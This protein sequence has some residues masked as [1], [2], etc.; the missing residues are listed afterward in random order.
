MIVS[1]GGGVSRSVCCAAPAV[2]TACLRINDLFRAPASTVQDLDE[3]AAEPRRRRGN[4]D[5]GRFHGLDLV[6]RAAPSPCNDRATV[7]QA[8]PRRRGQAGDET[9][10][11][12]AAAAEPLVR[13]EASR[14][15][16]RRA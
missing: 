11:R 16:L 3:R 14:L 8:P 7:T 5:S 13:D 15:L 1:R 2:T 9:D 6:F 10:H 12:L 4:M